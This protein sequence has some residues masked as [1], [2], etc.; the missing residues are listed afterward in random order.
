MVITRR[1]TKIAQAMV[2]PIQ[3]SAKKPEYSRQPVIDL[4]QKVERTEPVLI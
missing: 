3:S 4:T 2:P 1:M